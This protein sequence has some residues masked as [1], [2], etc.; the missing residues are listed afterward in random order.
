M[1]KVITFNIRYTDD[2][3]GNSIAERAP[4]LKKIISE[5]NPD[6][7]GFQECTPAWLE[8]IEKYWSDEYE[9]F[10][11]YRAEK[12]PESAPILWR[13]DKFE[14]LKKGF[15]WLSDT[16]ETESGGWDEI[17]CFRICCYAVLKCRACGKAFTFMNTHFGFGDDNQVKSAKLIKEKCDEISDFPAFVTGDFN[18][19]PEKAGYDAMTEFFTDVNAVTEKDFNTTYHGY[20]KNHTGEHI[21]YCFADKRIKPV[22]SKVIYDLVDGKFP[23]DHYGIEFELKF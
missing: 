11:K 22:S 1:P 5:R 16:P 12:S 8:H 17:G 23:S 3:N 13:R 10:N 15:F 21:D 20:D 7:I 19:T 9:I 4:R 6:L 14:C 18:M 2:P